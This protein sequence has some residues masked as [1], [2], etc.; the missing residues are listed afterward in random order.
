MT[1]KPA[2]NHY[3]HERS[4]A[5]VLKYMS[6]PKYLPARDRSDRTVQ[7]SDQPTRKKC[8]PEFL[9]VARVRWVSDDADRETGFFTL[10]GPYDIWK[11]SVSDPRV[12]VRVIACN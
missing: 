3:P 8:F 11:V 6:H 10:S 1:W 2:S 12:G 5:E 4:L 9:V 7:R